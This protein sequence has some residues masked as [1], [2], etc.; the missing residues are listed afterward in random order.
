MQTKT[1]KSVVAQIN[2]FLI[3]ASSANSASQ[4]HLLILNQITGKCD[5]I[6]LSGE[7]PINEAKLLDEFYTMIAVANLF[8]FKTF[9]E[10]QA[11]CSEEQMELPLLE[12]I[13]EY[14]AISEKC[15]F[16][17]SNVGSVQQI[18]ELMQYYNS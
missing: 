17:L 2:G 7:L 9:D 6:I 8:G 4:Y 5:S 15:S 14:N 12:A 10:Y 18:D 16:L 11:V 13:E 1:N 3:I